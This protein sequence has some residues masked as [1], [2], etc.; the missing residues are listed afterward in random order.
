MRT[1]TLTLS[2]VVHVIGVC[3]LIIAPLFATDTLPDPRSAMEFI[4]AVPLEIP[5]PP[6]LELARTPFANP[7]AAP[8]EAP[9][10]IRPEE[11]AAP[12]SDA[13]PVDDS[14]I[15]FGGD[16]SFV[17]VTPPPPPQPAAPC[18]SVERSGRRRR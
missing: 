18:G 3:A 8:L 1:A 6:P 9:Q 13:H 10:G 17:D 15:T 2:I 5:T 4:R 11:P 16:V 14:L 7:D 12:P